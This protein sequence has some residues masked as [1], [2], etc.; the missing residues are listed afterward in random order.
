[1]ASQG[2]GVAVDEETCIKASRAAGVGW[3]SIPSHVP[4]APACV[5]E[6]E[7]QFLQRFVPE[8]DETNLAPACERLTEENSTDND[9]A[10]WELYCCNSAVCGVLISDASE[11]LRHSRKWSEYCPST[12]MPVHKLIA[13]LTF[14]AASARSIIDRCYK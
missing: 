10:L 11:E 8:Y 1:M 9:P 2:N 6:C 14:A 7:K 13:V 3:D 12:R 5:E 4:N